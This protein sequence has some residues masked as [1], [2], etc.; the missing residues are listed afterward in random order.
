MV[1]NGEFCPNPAEPTIV[2]LSPSN[3][4]IMLLM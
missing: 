3:V 1:P 2:T 4:P